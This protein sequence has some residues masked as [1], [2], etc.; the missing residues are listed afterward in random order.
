VRTVSERVGLATHVKILYDSGA[1]YC[2]GGGHDVLA[3]DVLN[4]EDVNESYDM[5]LQAAIEGMGV[6]LQR[7]EQRTQEL[8]E[9][10]GRAGEG[11]DYNEDKDEE[12]ESLRDAVEVH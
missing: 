3:D 11:W 1:N 7:G 9:K 8:E 5:S 6:I 12:E 10:A 2:E 4:T